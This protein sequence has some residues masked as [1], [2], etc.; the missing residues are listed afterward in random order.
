MQNSQCDI[1]VAGGGPAGITTAVKLQRLGY[2][3]LLIAAGTRPDI[4]V[5]QTISPGVL[6]LVKTI[7]LD[8][9][10]I[11]RCLTPI[12]SSR[13]LWTEIEEEETDPAGFLV[14]RH[15]F[16]NELLVNA[17]QLGVTVMKSASVIGCHYIND[18]WE[19]NLNQ[20][21]FYSTFSTKFMVDATGKKSVLHA[22]KKRVMAP[23]IAITGSWK[24]TEFPVASTFL[25]SLSNHFLWGARLHD[26]VFHATV[27]IDPSAIPGR[28]RLVERY[29]N[30]IEKS[31]L[32]SNC[33][34]GTLTG[35]LSAV[36]VTPYFHE[37]PAG[38]NFVRVG[39]ACLGLDPLS[40]QGIQTAMANALQG[41]IFVN[42]IFSH[43]SRLDIAL[44]FYKSR[45]LESIQQHLRMLSKNYAAA[46]C[47]REQPFWK[48]RTGA[49]RIALRES[50]AAYTYWNPGSMIRISRD[51]IFKPVACI[52]KDLITSKI[53]ILHPGLDG[54]LVYW[55]NL[56][57]GKLIEDMN[58]SKTLSDL[59][60][61]W[62]RI[63]P[64]EIATQLLY[65]LKGAG[66]LEIEG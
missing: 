22:S 49:G 59:I 34:K 36:D 28:S 11:G 35:K 53:G 64:L 15:V 61:S 42:T 27:F 57:I 39:E 62:S 30:S 3:V 12:R 16:D 55:H 50:G 63:M 25:E 5:I 17:E 54:P 38:K 66:V 10:K 4:P 51:A 18:N 32:F 29:I 44:E 60:Q 9:E 56:E 7:G 19:L 46:R 52:E 23:T 26:G 41:A 1:C 24:N 65:R 13:I 14:H 40:S 48:K 21:G 37:N 33:L 47:W 58:I 45:L 8:V 2:N 6:T 31:Q 43:P 20:E